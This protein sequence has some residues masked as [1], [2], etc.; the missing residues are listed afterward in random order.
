MH[1]M[2]TYGRSRIVAALDG[3]ERGA[4]NIATASIRIAA[5]SMAV[6]FTAITCFWGGS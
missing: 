3:D 5:A 2:H 6:I 4:A 1:H